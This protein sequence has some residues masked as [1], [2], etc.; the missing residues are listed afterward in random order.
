MNIYS[1]LVQPF[2]KIH[3]SDPSPNPMNFL[4]VIFTEFN[5]LFQR[6]QSNQRP[7]TQN[8]STER[9]TTRLKRPIK[10]KLFFNINDLQPFT[11]NLLEYLNEM[12]NMLTCENVEEEYD[13]G[14]CN[15]SSTCQEIN[16][17][18]IKYMFSSISYPL[19]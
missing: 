10:R 11:V 1:I 8:N 7:T 9:T 13:E 14:L 19:Y 15:L 17:P 4:F 3:K 2:T 5:E 12:R 6:S 16:Y 18:K